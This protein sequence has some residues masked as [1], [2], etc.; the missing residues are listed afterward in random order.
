MKNILKLLL[1]IALFSI[2]MGYSRANDG[3]NVVT[4]FTCEIF[5]K[6][7]VIGEMTTAISKSSKGYEISTK[8]NIEFNSLWGKRNVRSN[9]LEKFSSSGVL[10]E[11][12]SMVLDG[13]KAFWTKVARSNNELWGS[14]VQVRSVS[15]HDNKELVGLM[16]NI[17]GLFIPEAGGVMGV[18]F[19]THST[20]SRKNVRFPQ[21]SHHSSLNN[22]P[23]Y[24]LKNSKNFPDKINILDSDDLS[25]YKMSVEYLGVEEVKTR[26]RL[27]SAKHYVL[28]SK[29][30]FLEKREPL[31]IWLAVRRGIPFFVQLKGK[32]NDGFFHVKIR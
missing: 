25:I 24:W 26:R 28:K 27:F 11:S 29:K 16:T 1:I 20:T 2:P 17:G 18:V 7:N 14:S 6:G 13:K 12:D 30:T 32:D 3:E 31:H 22:L 10:L 15:E 4:K 5:T 8:R 23:F 9:L 19:G 21:D